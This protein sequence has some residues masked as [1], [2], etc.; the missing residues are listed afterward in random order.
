MFSEALSIMKFVIIFRI[1]VVSSHS[2]HKGHIAW[3]DVNFYKSNYGD[4]SQAYYQSKLANVMYAKELARRLLEAG[5]RVFSVHPG[6]V[7]TAKLYDP[8]Y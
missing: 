6:R 3:K 2:H 7:V 5:I 8:K 1:V 4:G